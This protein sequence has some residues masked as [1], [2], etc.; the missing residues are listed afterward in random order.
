MDIALAKMGGRVIVQDQNITFKILWSQGWVKSFKTNDKN[1][2]KMQQIYLQKQYSM[3][4]IE[5]FPLIIA[6]TQ[7]NK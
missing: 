6:F 1:S 3:V 4:K 7:V 5:N 2:F